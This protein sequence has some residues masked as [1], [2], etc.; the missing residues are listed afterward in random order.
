MKTHLI[1]LNMKSHFIN[2]QSYVRINMKLLN[3]FDWIGVN[4]N[5]YTI[6]FWSLIQLYL[7][8]IV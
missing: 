8:D 3:N 5:K 4:N 2:E 6:I 1:K 7:L